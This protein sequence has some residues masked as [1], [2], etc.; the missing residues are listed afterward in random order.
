MKRIFNRIRRRAVGVVAALGAVAAL[1]AT[2]PYVQAEDYPARPVRIIVPFAPGGP[3]DILARV[4]AQK[5]GERL[6]RQFYVEDQPGAGGNIGMGN[7][8]HATPDGYTL[9]LVS[10]SFTVNPSLYDKIPYDPVKDFAPITLAVNVPN[11]L[12]VNPSVP[13]Q[14]VKELAALVKSRAGTY[15]FAS[16]GIGTTPHLS[17]EIFHL[18]TGA[19]LVHVPFNG[20]APAMQSAM[21]GHT[22]I[23]F[24]VLSP[25]AQLIKEGKLRALAILSA[26]R[27]PA[28]PDVPSIVEAGFPEMAADTQQGV[29]A[30]AGTPKEIVDLLNREIT[31]V[32][33]LPDVV[34]HLAILGFV[35]SVNTPAAYA[36]QIKSEIARWKKVVADAHIKAE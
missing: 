34:E 26:T 4:L 14:D 30:P 1:L 10:T 32:L 25:A 35:P 18:L 7:A 23:A 29:L 5:L 11:V 17:G 33:A 3:A 21:G 19:D 9:V 12:V 31:A 2:V 28:L 27:S 16:A 13:A 6:G 15:N 24:I 22:P 20:S 8:A 36:D